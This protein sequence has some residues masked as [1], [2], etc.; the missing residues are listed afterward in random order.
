MDKTAIYHLELHIVTKR[1][2]TMLNLLFCEIPYLLCFSEWILS[3]VSYL[4]GSKRSGQ[5]VMSHIFGSNI[6]VQNPDYIQC[7][8]ENKGFF[9]IVSLLVSKKLYIYMW[10]YICMR[11]YRCVYIYSHIYTLYTYICIYI[12]K[13]VFLSWLRGGEESVTVQGISIPGLV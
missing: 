12:Y 4:S 1:K 2:Y 8:W 10:I 9:P 11:I 5:N 13:C 6:V 7:S 3:L